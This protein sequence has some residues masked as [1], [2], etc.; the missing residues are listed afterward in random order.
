MAYNGII[1]PPVLNNPSG[2]DIQ[3]ALG[4]SSGAVDVLCKSNNIN[5]WA[6]YKPVRHSTKK[7]I[8]QSE[9]NSVA[10]GLSVPYFTSEINEAV[11]NIMQAPSYADVGW[12]YLKPNGGNNAP[13]RQ[14]DFGKT[15]NDA[16]QAPWVGTMQGYNH[17]AKFPMEVSLDETG[18][19]RQSGSY[20]VNIQIISELKFF[21]QNPTGD[22]LCIQDFIKWGIQGSGMT[23]RPFFYL[24]YGD[25]WY[26]SS[27]QP[28]RYGAGSEFSYTRTNTPTMTVSLANLV[29]NQYYHLC[30]GI[31]CCDSAG[32]R[33]PSSDYRSFIAPF[34]RSS[35]FTSQFY[36]KF[37]ITNHE[38]R[39]ISVTALWY[40]DG[41][42]ATWVQA[43][44]DAPYFDI[45][46]NAADL[47]RLQFNVSEI[48]NVS[49]VYFVS[50][51]ASSPTP[52][53]WITAKESMNGGAETTY[54]LTPRNSSWQ[55]PSN[56]ERK[57]PSGPTSS[58]VTLYA[59]M[60][61]NIT[62]GQIKDYHMYSTT[63]KVNFAHNGYFRIRKV[64]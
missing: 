40:F 56:N 6:R 57:I 26:S 53:F 48:P 33:F 41:G 44:G 36:Y 4:E 32:S 46:T 22:D 47:I 42:R 49:D 25:S 12:G 63:D 11:Y 52:R 16:S 37:R 21:F 38:E 17:Q 51:N 3:A 64:N 28:T 43:S 5:K 54:Y 62:S 15:P 27:T 45:A 50:E 61:T 30:I 2:G 8:T 34:D 60:Y 10:W 1:S 58:Y 59:E 20:D 18:V 23:W 7:P 13:Y 24:Y 55:A 29:Q 39:K 35:R 31:G 19:T 9:R 14:S